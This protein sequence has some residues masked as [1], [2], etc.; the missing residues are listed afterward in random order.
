VF[1]ELAVIIA[2]VVGC[3]RVLLGDIF[4]SLMIFKA[5]LLCFIGD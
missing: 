1:L 3:K 2:G 4:D 5:V